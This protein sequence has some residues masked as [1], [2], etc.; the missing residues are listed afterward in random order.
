MVKRKSKQL[1][2]CKDCS[3]TGFIFSLKHRKYEQCSTCHGVRFDELNEK[4]KEICK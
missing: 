1:E 4:Q 2:R 3:G